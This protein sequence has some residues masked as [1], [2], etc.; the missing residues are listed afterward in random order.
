MHRKQPRCLTVQFP[1]KLIHHKC[2]SKPKQRYHIRAVFHGKAED[3]EEQ[4][5]SVETQGWLVDDCARTWKVRP[6]AIEDTFGGIEFQLCIQGLKW[7][8]RK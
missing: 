2:A 4:R 3:L 6:A 7:T 1:T 8:D 5:R